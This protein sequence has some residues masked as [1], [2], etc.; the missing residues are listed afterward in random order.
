MFLDAFNF[1]V[2]SFVSVIGWFMSY[3]IQPGITYGGIIVIMLVITALFKLTLTV[4]EVSSYVDQMGN[5]MTNPTR[6]A[7]RGGRTVYRE[8]KKAWN[9]RK[10]KHTKM[11]G[12]Q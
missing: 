6:A 2:S 4:F 5:Y 9:S 3:Q 11:F 12:K 1:F 10:E 8:G 7:K